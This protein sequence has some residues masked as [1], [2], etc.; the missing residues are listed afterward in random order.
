V[1]TPTYGGK[2]VVVPDCPIVRRAKSG[3]IPTARSSTTSRTM[4]W[5]RMSKRRK[6]ALAVKN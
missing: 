2:G 1:I 4:C 6:A 5:W 3:S